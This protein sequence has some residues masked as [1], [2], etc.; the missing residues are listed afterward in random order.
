[1]NIDDFKILAVLLHQVIVKYYEFE[2]FIQAENMAQGHDKKLIL[3][4]LNKIHKYN[5]IAYTMAKFMKDDYH[6]NELKYIECSKDDKNCL[7]AE[8]ELKK[9][10]IKYPNMGILTWST[11]WAAH[12][13][14]KKHKDFY[15][16]GLLPID[17]KFMFPL[18]YKRMDIDKIK[19]NKIGI[20]F[21]TVPIHN[22]ENEQY[23]KINGNNWA[24][25]SHAV[26][27]FIN[28]KE[29]S[30]CYFDAYGRPPYEPIMEFIK[31]INKYDYTFEY[32][33][34]EHQKIKSKKQETA[35]AIYSL[36]F[37]NERIKGKSC[38]SIFNKIINDK[39]MNKKRTYFFK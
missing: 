36:N 26:A 2:M 19:Q 23:L 30:I 7:I 29:K 34:N 10:V 18:M 33:K 25:L 32:N 20:I 16:Y 5:P 4:I 21:S 14:E 37:I 8:Q 6:N 39:D 15:F 13:M 31:K 11:I 1:M 9:L 22:Y 35:C 3:R 38:K 28:K 12:D 27:I 17:F 24:F